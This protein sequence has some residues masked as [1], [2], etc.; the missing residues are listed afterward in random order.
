MLRSTGGG[1]G[2]N[3]PTRGQRSP[4]HELDIDVEERQGLLRSGSLPHLTAA[5]S[6]SP[7][8]SATTAANAA[9]AAAGR[10]RSRMSR[11]QKTVLFLLGIALLGYSFLADQVY[12]WMVTNE[13]SV[14]LMPAS[15]RSCAYPALWVPF[16]EAIG[17]I[18]SPLPPPASSPPVAS[19]AAALHPPPR[20]RT[21]ASS[22]PP[23]AAAA[24][25]EID[26]P[27]SSSTSPV[28]RH[29]L[30]ISYKHSVSFLN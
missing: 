28:K 19:A 29:N 27:S 22:T 13:I 21:D 14:M 11:T 16:D 6:S 8:T 10:A 18:S 3:T 9:A 25:A 23:A 15:R 5:S 20:R 26:V 2:G 4:S 7:P 12:L 24:A 30:S 1:S 17:L